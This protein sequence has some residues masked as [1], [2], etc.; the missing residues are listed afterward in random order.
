MSVHKSFD[1]KKI[2]R[3]FPYVFVINFGHDILLDLVKSIEI[4]QKLSNQL[5]TQLS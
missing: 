3:D 4:M 1:N 2:I 5:K